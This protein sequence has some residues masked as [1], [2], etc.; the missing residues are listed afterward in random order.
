M[1]N[2]LKSLYGADV[3]VEMTRTNSL[4][5]MKSI[6]SYVP[7]V[8]GKVNLEPDVSFDITIPVPQLQEFGPRQQ[9][10][11]ER[12]LQSMYGAWSQLVRQS[13]QSVYHTPRSITPKRKSL[14]PRRASNRKSLTP[15]SNR[16][17]RR[18]FTPK[19]RVSM[20]MGSRRRKMRSKKAN[21]RRSYK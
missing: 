15:S 12:N 5:L 7:Y 21:K 14:T 2:Q 11:M 8:S 13:P 16:R 18:S 9:G 20:A 10:Y 17:S 1:L 4:P 6:A 19:K 3:R